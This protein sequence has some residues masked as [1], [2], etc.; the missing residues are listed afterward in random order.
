M[1]TKFAPR[2][3][4]AGYLF[5]ALLA[6]GAIVWA[7][8][9]IWRDVNQ[10][11]QRAE[12]VSSDGFHLSG[13]LESRLR[14][15][16]DDV[17]RYSL[18]ITQERRTSIERETEALR[19][20]LAD[21]R[22]ATIAPQQRELLAR[23]ETLYARYAAHA[24]LLLQTNQPVISLPAWRDQ[25][26]QILGEMLTLA[27]DLDRVEKAALASFMEETQR[28]MDVLFRKLILSSLVLLGMGAV[29]GF[30]T[31]RGVVAPLRSR[32]RESQAVIER[33]EKLSSLGVLA[34]GVAH[35]IRNPLTSIKARLFTQQSLLETGS[36]ALEDNVFIT[37][38]IS[39]LEKIVADFLAFARPSEPQMVPLKA[40]Q[41]IRD[42]EGLFRPALTKANIELKKEFLADPR[43]HA[44]PAQLKQ[45]L[46]NLVQNAAESM[47]RGGVIILRTRTQRRHRP[48]HS[49]GVAVIEVED[50]GPGIPPDV[51]KRLFDPFFTTKPAGTGL[52]L[53]IAARILEK[54]GGTL[55][56]Q[57]APN[58]GTT[59]RLVLPIAATEHE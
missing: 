16:N 21:H 56:Y 17:F 46:I 3:R 37:G 7:E 23:A 18:Q 35:E 30:L 1:N 26:E 49:P 2:R 24:G 32:L 20:W 41:P 50:T 39:R 14:A 13:Q 48:M 57:T 52:G 33:Q 29:L 19:Q 8:S 6:I 44:D 10:V 43:I 25:E 15:L 53:S 42:L 4:A 22:D 55:E 28:G 38:E 11:R 27:R 58:R 51:Q 45:V 31:Y 59:F 5:G 47:G 12:L 34:A 36:E 9:V 54:H 40:T